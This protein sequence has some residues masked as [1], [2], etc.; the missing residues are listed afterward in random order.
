MRH[1]SLLA[2]LLWGC[3][4]AAGQAVF[5]IYNKVEGGFAVV[6]DDGEVVGYSDEGS[7]DTTYLPPAMSDW[8]ECAAGQLELVRQGKALRRRAPR[9]AADI[10]PMVTARWG[11]RLPFNMMAPEYE[12]NLHCA[13]GCVAVAMAQVLKYWASPVSTTGIPA[14]KT[15]E[16]GLQLEALPPRS[17][18]Y[19]IMRD[20]YGMFDKDA[21]AQEVAA[22]MRYCG[23][24]AEMD[25]DINSGAS[26]S[27]AYLA[28]FFGFDSSYTDKDY[29]T[30]MSGWDDLIYDELAAGR[31][32]MYSGKKMS[33]FLKFSG[34][35]FVVDGFDGN[36]LFHFNWGWNGTDDGY[37]KLTS[38]DGY[39]LL[40][41]AV[42]GLQPAGASA[43]APPSCVLSSPSYPYYDLSG[44]RILQPASP[45]LYI[46]QGKK[47][48]L[49]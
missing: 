25:Y 8:M 19:S 28:R 31:P 16:L 32:V 21:G 44:R 15:E 3:L 34:H 27:G 11:Q 42:I 17:F 35:V 5:H 33:G 40:Q 26:T 30:H 24:A 9:R 4:S 6:T 7:V 22:L 20:E 36:G 38:A 46:H 43:V 10:E 14:Y 23:Q 1:L 13:A 39:N 47:V 2:L 41:M 48:L 37:F 12:E 29:I 45:G 18:D 49:P